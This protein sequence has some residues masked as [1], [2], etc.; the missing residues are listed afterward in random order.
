MVRDLIFER[1]DTNAHIVLP[2]QALFAANPGFTRVFVLLCGTAHAS[3]DLL[4]L[5]WGCFWLLLL[6]D[7]L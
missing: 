6:L 7:L 3:D 2:G 1:A 5:F 4:G